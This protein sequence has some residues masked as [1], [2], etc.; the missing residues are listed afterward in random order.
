MN[1]AEESF[2]DSASKGHG[3]DNSALHFV[4][5][6]KVNAVNAPVS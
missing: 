4:N 1:V 3:G 5:A 2:K 6:K